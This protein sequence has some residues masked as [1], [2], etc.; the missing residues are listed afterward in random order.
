[1]NEKRGSSQATIWILIGIA[2]AI[3]GGLKYKF[4]ND[5]AAAKEKISEAKTVREEQLA[6][7][8]QVSQLLKRADELRSLISDQNNSISAT[9]N[10]FS[11]SEMSNVL[12]ERLE[13]PADVGILVA[14]KSSRWSHFVWA[15]E[16]EK[17][18]VV[19][20]AKLVPAQSPGI[21]LDLFNEPD[22]RIE[23]PLPPEQLTP[24]THKLRSTDSGVEFFWQLG[25]HKPTTIPFDGFWSQ[26]WSTRGIN[27]S[28]ILPN[29]LDVNYAFYDSGK[30]VPRRESIA[31]LHK[32]GIWDFVSLSVLKIKSDDDTK[33]LKVAVVLESTGP[34][35][36][37]V[38]DKHR[39]ND[40][41]ELTWEEAKAGYRIGPK[42][43]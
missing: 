40:G 30:L 42:P 4:S 12:I 43:E 39:Y 22:H 31:A 1:M 6:V 37:S 17:H 14:R 28:A 29:S 21:N 35:Y 25:E 10:A 23:I 3:F 16:G 5:L 26:G 19:L 18:N 13:V 38:P 20:Y 9:F 27:V 34:F 41:F 24:M 32:K 7:I 15:P 33:R 11:N 8:D 2:L 36:V